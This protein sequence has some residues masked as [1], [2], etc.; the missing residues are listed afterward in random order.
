MA[1]I[2]GPSQHRSNDLTW[3]HR[4]FF[5]KER[6]ASLYFGRATAVSKGL[7]IYKTDLKA[8]TMKSTT[9]FYKSQAGGETVINY[10]YTDYPIK[11]LLQDLRYLFVYAWSI[12]R[13]LMPLSPCG[14]GDLD[15]LYPS[16]KNMFCVAV[17]GVLATLQLMF[18]CGLPLAVFFPLWMTGI[19][20]TGFFILNWMLCRLLNGSELVYYSDKKYAKPDPA[21]EHEQWVYLNGV[22]VGT[23]WLKNNLNRL[24]VTFHRPV[25]GIHNRTSGIV[26]DLLECLFQRNF[27]YATRDIRQCYKELRSLL[28]KKHLTKVIFICHSQGGIEGSLVLD[29]LLQELPQD[30]LSKLEVYTFGNA[31]NH[32]NNPHRHLASL[33][34]EQKNPLAA[35]TTTYSEP[36]LT[37]PVV[38]GAEAKNGDGAAQL[39]S[40][41]SNKD[42]LASV[43]SSKPRKCVAAKDKAIGHIEHYTHTTDFVALWG[44]LHFYTNK[45]GS[46]QLPRFMGR[47]FSR[48][49]GHGG[50][51]L[52][53]HY[54][55]GMFPL[56]RDGNGKW[57]GADEENEWM[58]EVVE[59]A[60]ET[61]KMASAREPLEITL[62]LTEGS[63]SDITTISLKEVMKK[64]DKRGN[65]KVKELSRLWKYRN[66]LSPG[67][68]MTNGEV[69]GARVS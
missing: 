28:Y 19:G 11:I 35:L 67:K 32:F 55:D 2:K 43:S 59:F 45:M 6:S 15:E 42:T 18:I 66:G 22:S 56:T 51:L 68:H 27:C 63:V 36:S 49:S 46:P 65:V 14:S 26:F 5:G 17:H 69:V 48:S 29:W 53:H 20:M 13:V 37:A 44:V 54:L 62:S 52:N 8:A 50:H 25:M 57:K 30:L 7:E 12:P 3:N 40:M 39:S 4:R 41:A 24:A 10:S 23:H 1:L 47:L 58:E 9:K 31:A 64:K 34:M 38:D 21:H 16:Y 61:G 33:E 60:N